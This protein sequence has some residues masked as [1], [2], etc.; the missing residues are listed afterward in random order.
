MGDR[1]VRLSPLRGWFVFGMPFLGLTPQ[2]MYLSRLGRLTGMGLLLPAPAPIQG[3]STRSSGVDELSCCGDDSFDVWQRGALEV[4]GVRQGV[5]DADP[6]EA[7]RQ[8]GLEADR[9]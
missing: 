7:R 4:A 6:A 8:T 1:L 3:V 2:A 9:R 5:L